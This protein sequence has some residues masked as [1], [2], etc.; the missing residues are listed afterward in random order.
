MPS[1][2][3]LTVDQTIIHKE[4]PLALLL[5]RSRG[6]PADPSDP[7]LSSGMPLRVPAVL[8]CAHLRA[9]AAPQYP[10]SSPSIVLL[11]VEGLS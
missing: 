5:R 3:R 6:S 11:Q 2:M 4:K 8:P 1:V 7:A 10:L 9:A